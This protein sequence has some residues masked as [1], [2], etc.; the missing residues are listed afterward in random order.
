MAFEQV[1]LSAARCFHFPRPPLP[2]ALLA[3]VTVNAAVILAA[4]A[5]AFS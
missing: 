5:A 2:L 1:R 4:A 3:R